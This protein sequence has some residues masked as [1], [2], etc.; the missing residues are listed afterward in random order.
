M[1]L[2]MKH[3]KLLLDIKKPQ[4]KQEEKKNIESEETQQINTD[5]SFMEFGK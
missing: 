2:V 4:K 3:V 1:T 5:E